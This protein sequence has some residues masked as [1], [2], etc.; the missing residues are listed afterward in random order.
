MESITGAWQL[1]IVTGAGTGT[2]LILRWFWWRINAWSEVSAMVAAFVVSIF[3]Q[4]AIGWD[5]NDPIGFA[6]IM[7]W[8][9][10]VTTGVWLAVTFATPPEPEEKLVSFYRRVRPFE[11]F[12][13]PVARKAPDVKASGGAMHDFMDWIC[14]CALIYGSLFGIGKIVLKEFT[15]GFLYLAVAAVAGFVIY[16]DLSRRGWR[17]VME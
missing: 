1:L 12:W 13:R 15:T 4:T 14:G 3:L 10:G 16:R 6:K 2:V 11:R 9:V 17:T 7:L 5:S 8:T